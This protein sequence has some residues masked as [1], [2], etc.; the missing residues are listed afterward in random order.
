MRWFEGLDKR[1]YDGLSIVILQALTPKPQIVKAICRQ[2]DKPSYASYHGYKG[3]SRYKGLVIMKDSIVNHHRAGEVKEIPNTPI[4]KQTIF[5][6]Y[7]G[8]KVWQYML[9]MKV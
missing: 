9:D 7:K 1:G 8:L 4:D 2:I 5:S 6:G 3:L